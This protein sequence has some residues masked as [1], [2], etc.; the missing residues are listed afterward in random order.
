MRTAWLILTKGIGSYAGHPALR[1][2]S[3]L[4]SKRAHPQW[5]G[6]RQRLFCDKMALQA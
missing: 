6:F 2:A 1:I 5:I 3:V 4:N